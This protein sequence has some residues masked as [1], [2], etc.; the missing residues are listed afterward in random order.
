[1]HMGPFFCPD[2]AEVLQSHWFFH[3]Y[4][5]AVLYANLPAWNEIFYGINIVFIEIHSKEESVTRR[6]EYTRN[7]KLYEQMAL[8]ILDPNDPTAQ[9][10]PSSESPYVGNGGMETFQMHYNPNMR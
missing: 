9:I 1:M 3:L 10:P 2:Q 8:M 4:F 6:V 5:V 7:D